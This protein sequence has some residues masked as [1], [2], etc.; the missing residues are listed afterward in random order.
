VDAQT[1]L[2]QCEK[3]GDI[4]RAAGAERNSDNQVLR[5]SDPDEIEAMVRGMVE[6][7][8]ITGGDVIADAHHI[9]RN[10]PPQAIVRY[11][12]LAAGPDRH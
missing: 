8:G 4:L 9:P 6:T 5:R 1:I 10:I 11:L 2:L 7:A 3:F 12:D